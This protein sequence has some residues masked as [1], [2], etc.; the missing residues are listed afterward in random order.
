MLVTPSLVK[1]DGPGELRVHEKADMIIV[2]STVAG[3]E[4]YRDPEKGTLFIRT[5]VT[6]FMENAY[7]HHVADLLQKVFLYLVNHFYCF[8]IETEIF[9]RNP[10]LRQFIENFSILIITYIIS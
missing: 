10:V 1:D 4:S 2:Y 8:Y 7:K 3:Y 6:T 9:H 5:L